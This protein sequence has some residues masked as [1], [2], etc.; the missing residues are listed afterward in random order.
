MDQETHLEQLMH[1]YIGAY[2]VVPQLKD[3]KGSSY[4]QALLPYGSPLYTG[5]LQATGYFLLKPKASICYISLHQ[6][7]EEVLVQK[8]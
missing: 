6:D 2:E 7:Q 5:I 4:T 3:E 1:Y 8:T